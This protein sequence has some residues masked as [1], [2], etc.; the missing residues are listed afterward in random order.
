MEHVKSFE[1]Y[2]NES[3]AEFESHDEQMNEGVQEMA[4]LI[5]TI[6]MAAGIAKVAV[7]R[8][9]DN[10]KKAATKEQ[11]KTFAQKLQ[12]IADAIGDFSKGSGAGIA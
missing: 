12:L 1:T 11:P 10:Y 5:G 9:I 4:E 7:P 3:E 8:I 2:L 6:A